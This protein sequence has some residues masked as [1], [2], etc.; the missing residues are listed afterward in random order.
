M[1][2]I[3]SFSLLSGIRKYDHIEK[4]VTD[5]WQDRRKR[6]GHFW[7]T[8]YYQGNRLVSDQFRLFLWLISI[9]IAAQKNGN[10]KML[11][12]T[13]FICCDKNLYLNYRLKNENADN[14]IQMENIPSLRHVFFQNCRSFWELTKCIPELSKLSYL[15]S[16]LIYNTW[17]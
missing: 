2:T 16:T 11:G 8:F 10:H 9:H 15:S 1:N 4:N 17:V 7:S 14:R 13:E 3:W 6:G 12:F 5:I